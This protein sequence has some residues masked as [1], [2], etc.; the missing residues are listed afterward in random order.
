MQSKGKLLQ[1]YI[2]LFFNKSI[3]ASSIVFTS[4]TNNLD[5]INYS[6]FPSAGFL[7]VKKYP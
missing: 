3:L 2:S 1:F 4:K 6:E 5:I 7:Y